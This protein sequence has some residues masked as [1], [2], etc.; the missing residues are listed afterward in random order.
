MRALVLIAASVLPGS[1]G[2]TSAQGAQPESGTVLVREHLGRDDAVVFSFP[3]GVPREQAREEV[4]LAVFAVGLP[5]RGIEEGRTDE[6]VRRLELRTTLGRD[7][8]FLRRAVS[9]EVLE[10][11]AGR[12]G[13]EPLVLE[14]PAGAAVIRGDL[15]PVEAGPRPRFVVTGDGPIVYRVPIWRFLVPL[16]AL[17][18]ILVVPFP[19]LRRY[20]RGV[21]R[22][23]V[24][25]AEKVH[26]LRRATAGALL[27]I[28]L[29][30]VPVTLITPVT[31][32]PEMVLSEV[33]P[34]ATGWAAFRTVAGLGIIALLV[35]G[36][37]VS[38]S[39]AVQPVY[40]ELRGIEQ[41]IESLEEREPI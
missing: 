19:L 21:Q 33:A 6:R 12:A 40:R 31:A 39:L 23:P 35:V 5:N 26:R 8:G 30:V 15:E 20:V 37:L 28:L 14:L 38:V 22:V 10:A 4:E 32:V 18:T 34:A 9:G 2:H 11:L 13:P 36:S 27:I 25:T 17:V 1:E 29:L 24:E 7:A 3:T 16:A 41:R